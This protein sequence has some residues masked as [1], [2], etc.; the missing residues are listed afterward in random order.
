MWLVVTL[1]LAVQLLV[2][3]FALELWGGKEAVPST[4]LD[5]EVSVV[6]GPCTRGA[7]LT[8]GVGPAC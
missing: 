4:E 6:L 7:A 8:A 2:V 3:P 1:Y 5:M